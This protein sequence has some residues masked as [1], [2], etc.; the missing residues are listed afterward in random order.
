MKK[1]FYMLNLI[2]EWII[3][4]MSQLSVL[5]YLNIFKCKHKTIK[6]FYPLGL[7]IETLISLTQNQKL[8]LKE[9]SQANRNQPIC[10]WE[11]TSFKK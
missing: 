2:T 9:F 7:V 1:V 3:N 6:V 10:Y 8:F 11:H 5:I 4:A